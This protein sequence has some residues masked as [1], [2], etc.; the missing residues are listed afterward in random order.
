MVI[1]NVLGLQLIRA[2]S[3]KLAKYIIV[4]AVVWY[5]DIQVT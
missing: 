5:T 4:K 1:D 3:M 2:V